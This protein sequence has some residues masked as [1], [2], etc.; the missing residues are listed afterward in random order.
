MS[1]SRTVNAAIN[2]ALDELA[3]RNEDHSRFS[4]A[5]TNWASVTRRVAEL[6]EKELGRAFDSSI[7]ST[8]AFVNTVSVRARELLHS[9]NSTA[10]QKER[11]LGENA[12][13][14]VLKL[15]SIQN[16]K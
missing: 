15:F 7:S 4:A 14:V 10:A 9:R 12:R 2:T 3:A 8:N 11:E 13:D 16:G 5:K 1:C 6:L